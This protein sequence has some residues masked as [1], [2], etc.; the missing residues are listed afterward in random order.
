VQRGHF[1]IFPPSD[2]RITSVAGCIASGIHIWCSALH[3][4]PH[5]QDS[6]RLAVAV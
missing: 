2:S 1:T 5:A 3:V 4:A 6:R